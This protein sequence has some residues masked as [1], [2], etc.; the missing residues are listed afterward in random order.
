M[1]A[2]NEKKDFA[3]WLETL[4]QESWQ[5]ELII[6]GFAIFLLLGAYEPIIDLDYKISKLAIGYGNYSLLKVPYGVLLG[7]YYIFVIN[8][9]VHVLLRGLWISTL[10]LRYVSG[11]IDFDQLNFNPKFDT[12]L[13]KRI[14]S[15]DNYIENLEKLCSVIFAFTF[16]ITFILIAAGL[17]LLMLVGVGF[18]IDWA[19]EHISESVAISI[20]LLLVIL[21]LGAMLY[22]LDFITLGWLKR[23]KW[24]TP[25]YFPFYR[26]FSI[27]TFAF[28]YR[29][30]YYNLIDNKFGRWTGFM[31]V[32]YL[33][34]FVMVSSITITT[35]SFLPIHRNSQTL[36][37]ALYDDTRSETSLSTNASIPSKF[38]DN[39]FL[40]V[41]LPYV[42]NA[43]DKV[44][45]LI[46][47]DLKPA[48]T[49][50]GLSKDHDWGRYGMNPDSALLCN[51]ARY[52]IY[53]NDSL[54]QQP[55]YRFYDHPIRKDIGLLTI[56]DINYLPRGAHQVRVDVKFLQRRN[57]KDTLIFSTPVQIPFWKE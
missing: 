32:P 7:S 31:L 44:I 15:F 35:H 23:Q 3:K 6:S 4:Q 51:A 48:K 36:V 47:P 24:L 20:G 19:N 29:P 26:L 49:G 55:K 52:K 45:Q 16:L 12:F 2:K 39:G 25:F 43:N 8:L 18:L 46:C 10:G 56:L 38:V 30:I 17:F 5:L 42:D 41:Y 22:L 13:R 34:V 33:L 40:Q 53:I 9:I 28:I 11:D 37:T 27:L 21:L 57:R 14:G 1:D 54:F 50:I